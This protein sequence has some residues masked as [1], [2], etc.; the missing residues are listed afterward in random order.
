M[1]VSNTE[2]KVIE[3]FKMAVAVHQRGQLQ[4]A[5][6][7][8]H[9]ILRIKPRHFDALHLLGLIA[10]QSE[11]YVGA[12]SLISK[13]LFIEPGQ[14]VAHCNLGL[15]LQKMQRLNESIEHYDQAVS[16]KNDYA[17]AYCNRGVALKENQQFLEALASYDRAI[18][19]N[20]RYAVAHNNRA[21]ALKELNRF[22]EAIASYDIAIHINPYYAEAYSNRGVALMMS[23]QFT[24]AV[25]SFDK[26]I[27]ILPEFLDAHLNRGSSL[28]RLKLLVEAL[29]SY[30]TALRL[31][32][33]VEYV[34]GNIQHIR[35]FLC[36]WTDLDANINRL[37]DQINDG[38]KI[39]TSFPMLSLVDSA[40]IHRKVAELWV[41]DKHPS[42]TSLGI[43]PKASR[44]QKIRLG[45][46]SADFRNHPVSYLIAELLELHDRAAFE[47]L[48]FS[49][50]V[51]SHDPMRERLT[52]AF[53]QFIDIRT[54]SDKDV[55]S[56]AREMEIDIAI[57]LTGNTGEGRIGIFSYR[58]APIQINYLG[59]PGT[60]GADYYDYIVADP[61]VIPERDREH[62]V[63]KIIQ[64]PNCYQVNDGNRLISGQHFTRTGMGLPEEGFVF[65]CFNNCYKILP[66]IFDAWMRVL[67]E[68]QGSV[69]WLLDQHPI[70]VENLRREAQNRGISGNRLVFATKMPL[71][72]HLARHSLADLFVDTLPYNAHTTCSDA[73]WAGLP[74]LTCEGLS[75]PA[76]VSASLL[77][78]MGLPEL[79]AK[80]LK[81]YEETAIDIAKNPSKLAGIREK[82][83]SNLQTMP[84]FD[85]SSF[86]RQLEAA[87]QSV[88]RL[89]QDDLPPDHLSVEC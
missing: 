17:D 5:K 10:I 76:R 88:Y 15:A 16:L 78:A 82:V 70:A 68:V 46:F 2:L 1:L 80:S 67:S 24:Q 57:D 13:S 30:D 4:Q 79:I 52:A 19:L 87:Y 34:Q 38:N 55:A 39:S 26:A 42:N 3:L 72:D 47:V 66:N 60:I 23:G 65:C 14:A 63:E 83:R 29:E 25:S 12:I 89:Y 33:K 18:T 6:A 48:G 62:Y 85:T 27:E 45:Y 53:D 73:L 50:G 49:F 22:G 54:K 84:L 74:V 41:R 36:D 61:V 35:M 28:H 31:N 9:D 20:P 59:Y 44:K 21:N 32:P 58:A 71:P 81:D 86:T 51:D 75:F 77:R 11:D 56:L 7:I 69:L 64:L 40:P 37:I 8:Y 43:I